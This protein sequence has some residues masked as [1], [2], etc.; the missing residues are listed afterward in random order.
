VPDE[1]PHVARL[2]FP[3]GN[4]LP[5]L[6]DRLGPVFDDY[7]FAQLFPNKDQPAAGAIGSRLRAVCDRQPCFALPSTKVTGTRPSLRHQ[8]WREC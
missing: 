4:P 5:T 7:R 6:R 1:T 8:V 3:R 2:A